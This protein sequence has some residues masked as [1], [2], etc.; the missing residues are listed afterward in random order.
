MRASAVAGLLLLWSLGAAALPL[1]DSTEKRLA[2]YKA[3]DPW[4]RALEEKRFADV[5]KQFNTLIAD[6]AAGKMT[7]QE[8]ERWFEIFRKYNPGREPL[9]EDWIRQFPNSAAAH[10]AAAN[11]YEARGWNARGGEYSSKTSDAQFQ[12][13]GLEFRKAFESLSKAENL[14]ARPSLAAAMRMWMTAA[15]GDRKNQV[16]D[17]YRSAIKSFP[18]TLQVRVIWKNLSHPKWGGS[19]A[20]LKEIVGDAKSLGKDDR[21]YIE[22]LVYEELGSTYR[23]Q[24]DFDR[25]AEWYG[26][27]IPLCPGL[28][29]AL[30]A[31]LKMHQSR[32]NYEA[33]IPLATA[34][35]E[36]YPRN[37]WGW[38]MRGWAHVERKEYPQA[39]YDYERGAL[40]GSSYAQEGLAWLTEWGHGGIKQDYG[41]AIELYEIA[42][43]NGSKTAGEKAEKIR[44]G[45]GL[46]PPAASVK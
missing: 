14:M 20:Q 5:D 45:V 27:A 39:A 9:H 28:D 11:Y 3:M 38:A 17:I 12:A 31:D 32:K 26:K 6:T 22:Y 7:D 21:R 13:M 25:A 43:A 46:K 1:C 16:A 29:G 37:N 33:I 30:T 34:Y 36:R 4:Q 23:D 35:I 2:F 15:N 19:V 24:E 10:L 40:Y 18:E 8:L 44:K 42:A 41:K